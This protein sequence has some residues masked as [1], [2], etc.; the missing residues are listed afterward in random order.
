[1]DTGIDSQGGDLDV[2][3]IQV[4][5]DRGS[6]LSKSLGEVAQSLGQGVFAQVSHVDPGLDYNFDQL[7]TERS[8]WTGSLIRSDK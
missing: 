5:V 8:T 3:P 6:T 7:A 1:L 4:I 2:G